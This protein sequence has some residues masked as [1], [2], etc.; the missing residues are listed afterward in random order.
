MT[1]RTMTKLDD[2]EEEGPES[3]QTADLADLGGSIIELGSY[4]ELLA[5]S[6]EELIAYLPHTELG[7]L[8]LETFLVPGG[9]WGGTV[10][11]AR[12]AESIGVRNG[13]M[14]TSQKRTSG[15]PGSDHHTSQRTSF[16]VDMSNGTSPTPQ[17]LRTARQIAA[18]MGYNW[19]TD[20][21]NGLLTTR[22][23]ARGY[24]AQLIYHPY[25]DHH[26][27]VHFG[28]RKVR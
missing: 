21:R 5:L 13:L 10:A 8:S 15:N 24:R 7:T 14:I 11:P 19:D 17:M 2:Y 6:D 16:A 28:V 20:A 26:N 27:H 25:P 4:S 23:T 18:A 3:S 9:G 22:I 1:E 12:R